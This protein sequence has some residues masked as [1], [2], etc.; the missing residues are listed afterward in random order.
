MRTRQ[1]VDRAWFG[2]EAFK[3]IGRAFDEAWT[4]IAGNFGSDPHLIHAA[5]LQLAR[6]VLS[7]ASDDSR[8]AG[9]IRNAAM[10]AMARRYSA[11]N[12]RLRPDPTRTP[13]R[14]YIGR[15]SLIR[16]SPV[17]AGT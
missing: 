15:S 5:R 12:S 17:A 4:E 6:A 8:D 1:H 9:A 11:S 2:P 10:Q 3:V 7:V 14:R 13:H 16:Y